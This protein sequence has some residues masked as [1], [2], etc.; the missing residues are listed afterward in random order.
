MD[1][2]KLHNINTHTFRG[3]IFSI[4]EDWTKRM[5][6]NV[7]KELPLF[8]INPEGLSSQAVYSYRYPQKFRHWKMTTVKVTHDYSLLAVNVI[9]VLLGYYAA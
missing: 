5:S 8:V 3:I 1:G 6:R 2:T 9:F 7:G 4:L